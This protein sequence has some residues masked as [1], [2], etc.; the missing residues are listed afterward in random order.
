MSARW[1]SISRTSPTTDHSGCCAGVAAQHPLWSVVGEVLEIERH[2]ADM[3]A[4]GDQRRPALLLD[5]AVHVAVIRT[6][7]TRDEGPLERAD[8]LLAPELIDEVLLVRIQPQVQI[9]RESCRG[10]GE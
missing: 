2:L 5:N 8:E 1:R 10:R 4:G 7:R 3:P 6:Q 9:E